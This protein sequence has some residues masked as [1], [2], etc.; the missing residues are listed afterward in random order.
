MFFDK[1]QP[2]FYSKEEQRKALKFWADLEEIKAKEKK[3]K[4]LYVTGL[5]WA[6]FVLATI[7][8]IERRDHYFD[9]WRIKNLW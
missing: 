7:N 6:W 5:A 2:M 4:L 8:V 1:D 3:L 9:G